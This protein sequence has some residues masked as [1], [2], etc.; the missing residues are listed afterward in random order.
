LIIS[1][2]WK[3]TKNQITSWTSRPFDKDIPEQ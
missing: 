3:S 2:L 1:S